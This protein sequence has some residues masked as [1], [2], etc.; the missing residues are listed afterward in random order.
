MAVV[1]KELAS[2]EYRYKFQAMLLLKNVRCW[3][4]GGR[5]DLE[6]Y[7]TFLMLH[8]KKLDDTIAY[9]SIHEL[10]LMPYGARQQMLIIN[11]SE[12]MKT[13]RVLYRDICFIASEDDTVV[14]KLPFT[15]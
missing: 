8:G 15:E 2:C 10:L 13:R 6:V 7:H 11:L 4:T 1:V 9:T 12:P 5:Y 3:T 14:M